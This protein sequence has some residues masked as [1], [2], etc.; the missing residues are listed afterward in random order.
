M[1][2][3][4]KNTMTRD[5]MM[6]LPAKVVE[7]LLVIACSSLYTHIFVEGAVTGFNLTNTTVQ[8]IYLI[9]AGWMANSA[10][11]YVGEE[12]RAD[13]GRGL[14][15]TVSTIYLGLC[16][17]VAAG[18]GIT[19][20]VTGNTLYWG[21]ALMFCSYTAFQV[22]NAA[23]IQLGR[24]KAS[25]FWSLTSA[26]LK[27]AVAFALVGGKSNYPS[28]FP[29]IF[30]NTIADGVAAVGAVF[31][32][33][34]PAIVRLRCFSRPLLSRFLKYGVPLM[35]VSISVALLNQIDKYLVVGFYG[36]V[37]YAYYSTNNSIASGLF[38]MISVGIMR[39]VYPA[40]LRAWRDGGKAAAK[41]LLDV[42]AHRRPGGRRSDRSL[43]PDV[44]FPVRKGL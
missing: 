36:D 37:L 5:A 38:T 41:P 28:A 27:L 39:G 14:F 29:A 10:T 17:I 12:Y 32:L 33:G 42:P 24:V 3:S 9:L 20:A 11:R 2:L 26:S 4:S 18:C 22:L 40:V 44:A 7:G 34:L 16:V 25:I 6:F 15:S 13:S 1:T 19:A 23:L 30:A 8:L 35:G 21:G 43:A 31:A